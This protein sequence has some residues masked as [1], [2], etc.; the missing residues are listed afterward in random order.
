MGWVCPGASWLHIL[1]P[2]PAALG[3]IVSEKCCWGMWLWLGG[4]HLCG[5]VF[6]LV[7]LSG[8]CLFPGSEP[9]CSAPRAN[10]WESTQ[11]VHRLQPQEHWLTSGLLHPAQ[12]H[13]R[14]PVINE[15]VTG[16]QE[17][18]HVTSHCAKGKFR[19][20]FHSTRSCWSSAALYL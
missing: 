1:Q 19:V 7:S 14:A 5:G 3:R 8:K 13:W 17:W 10:P 6:T 12:D 9:W 18:E 15:Q 20:C 4:D 11:L 16:W 2:L